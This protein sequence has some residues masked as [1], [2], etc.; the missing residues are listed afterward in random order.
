MIT[1]AD[2]PAVLEHID[3][4]SGRDV[5][6]AMTDQ[7][8]GLVASDSA[9]GRHDRLL[10]LDVDVARSLVQDINGRVVQEGSSQGQTLPL[11]T[12]EVLSPLLDPGVQTILCA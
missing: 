8:H 5:C 12:G 1:L 9:H 11:A 3:P 7:D 2:H 6:Q 4:A 10:A